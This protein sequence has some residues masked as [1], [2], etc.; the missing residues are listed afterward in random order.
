MKTGVFSVIELHPKY[1]SRNGETQFVVLPYEEYVAIQEFLDG[2]E[3]LINLDSATVE[4]G[5]AAS[6][7]LEEAKRR[8]DVQ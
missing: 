6:I 1:L 8:L 4:E 5:K 3:D 2:I 7:S